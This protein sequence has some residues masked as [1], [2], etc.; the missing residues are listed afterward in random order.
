M[1]WWLFLVT[2]M[3]PSLW[4]IGSFLL[5]QQDASSGRR[6]QQAIEMGLHSVYIVIIVVIIFLINFIEGIFLG[7]PSRLACARRCSSACRAMFFFFSFFFSASSVVLCF[8]AEERLTLQSVSSSFTEGL[9]D[10]TLISPCKE[11]VGY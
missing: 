9:E 1:R 6:L 5:R 2:S 11:R 8:G 4:L 3:L 10:L 7:L